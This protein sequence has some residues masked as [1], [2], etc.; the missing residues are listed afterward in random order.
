M[1]GGVA[2]TGA[3]GLLG[4]ALAALVRARR[5]PRGG[6]G[7]RHGPRRRSLAVGEAAR[8]GR[9]PRLAPRR[10]LR[11][12]RRRRQP[13]GRVGRR[14]SLERSAQ[15]AAARQ[16]RRRHARP[17]RRPP[18]S[19]QA[20]AAADLRVGRRLLRQSRR[21]A[22]DGERGGRDRVP[23]RP[24]ARLGGRGDA[25]RR[26]RAACG[27]AAQRPGVVEEVRHPAQDPDAV[28]D[29]P[30]RDGRR[31]RTV[32]AVDSPRRS[33]R[34]RPARDV[35]RGRFGPAQLR[36]ARAGD[37]RGVRALAGRGAGTADGAEGA[38]VRA[39]HQVHLPV[40]G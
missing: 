38:A 31:R 40:R 35:A 15:E 18:R 22:A 5:Y 9:H 20:P 6:A 27:R 30:G 23:G 28:S 14:Q 7:P 12:R 37:A 39:S 34:P 8:V 36:R 3:T 32:A 1:Q 26:R 16:P 10:R 17:G 19:A 11:G 21:R 24:R 25:G 2:I 33:H 4:T 29:R 13:D